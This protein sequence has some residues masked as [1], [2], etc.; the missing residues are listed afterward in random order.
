MDVRPGGALGQSW[1]SELLRGSAEFTATGRP[2]PLPSP[3]PN[4]LGP[5]RASPG[6]TRPT[7]PL[8]HRP[9]ACGDGR[10]AADQPRRAFPPAAT[11]RPPLPPA[12]AGLPGT[13]RPRPSAPP[14]RE[15]P[16]PGESLPEDGS[17]P[18][19]RGSRDRRRH[20]E[21]GQRAASQ[22]DA[23]SSHG[24]AHTLTKVFSY[25]DSCQRKRGNSLPWGGGWGV[26]RLVSFKT[27]E[28]ET[29]RR[30]QSHLP[31]PSKRK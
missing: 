23:H 29:D 14:L 12:A 5:R 28:G 10:G 17:G 20:G 8:P 1:G 21:V 24:P 25:S 19:S 31:S 26:S 3:D 11:R 15:Q 6:D 9:P 18:A 22:T 16:A 13:A 2:L 7:H 30:R 4:A 27:R